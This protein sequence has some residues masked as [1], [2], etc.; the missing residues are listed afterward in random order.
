MNEIHTIRFQLQSGEVHQIVIEVVDRADGTKGGRTTE[1]LLMTQDLND[2]RVKLWNQ[3]IDLLESMLIVQ[4]CHG[5]NISS[6][7]YI[8][9]V[10]CYVQSIVTRLGF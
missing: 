5:V 6:P 7:G 3:A 9:G 8:A 2:F 10:K 1:S 4:A